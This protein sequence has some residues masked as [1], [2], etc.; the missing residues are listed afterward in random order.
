MQKFIGTGV[1]LVTPF[2]KDLSVDFN[3]LEKLVNFNIDNGT[4]YLVING[5]TGE[6]ATISEEEKQQIINKIATV[7]N[8]RLPLVL[9]VGGNNTQ[10]VV[11]ELK[12][13]DFTNIDGILSV[14]PYY[15]KPT[16]EGFYQHYK[17]VAEAT[18]LPIILYNVPGRTAKNMEP[19]TIIRLA[20]DFT[21]IVGVKEAA[22]VQQQ[23][24]TLL[25]NKPADFLVISGDDDLALGTTL[26]GGAGVISVIG[27]AYVKEFSKMIQLGL[28][29]KNIEAY[30]IHYRL[31]DIVNLIFAENNPAGIKALLQE[32]G[33]CNNTVRL[34]LVEASKELQSKIAD[35]V[36]SF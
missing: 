6:S 5:T 28:E 21:N 3:A 14:A 25:K 18:E 17:A 30:K 13:R 9:G 10:K 4:S 34:P 20:K 11:E 32:L 15:S 12:T 19:E 31:M 33:I 23:Y 8:K 29:G 36:K 35:Y 26:A 22:G 2:N 7:N 1:A 16:Q 27:Q 24:Y